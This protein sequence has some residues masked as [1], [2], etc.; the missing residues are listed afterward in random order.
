MG[1]ERFRVGLPDLVAP[2]IQAGRG[3]AGPIGFL[4]GDAHVTIQIVD[5]G[6]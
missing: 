2:S 5:G 3:L 4:R 1:A 6:R